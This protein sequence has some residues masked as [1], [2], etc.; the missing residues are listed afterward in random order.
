MLNFQIY[1]TENLIHCTNTLWRTLAVYTSYF[2]EELFQ[3]ASLLTWGPSLEGR[4]VFLNHWTF[5]PELENVQALYLLLWWCWY[6]W[7]GSKLL[8][9][10]LY[11]PSGFQVWSTADNICT[12]SEFYYFTAFKKLAASFKWLK[13]HI[14]LL[15]KTSESQYEIIYKILTFEKPC[16]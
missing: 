1:D 8:P 12:S 14:S 16:N 7:K 6:Y 5:Q 15:V 2:T 9:F 3:H 10:C 11:Q 13:C 4:K